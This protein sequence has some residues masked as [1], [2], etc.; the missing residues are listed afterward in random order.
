MKICKECKIEKPLSDYYALKTNKDG[1]AGKCKICTARRVRQN[2]KENIEYY[3]DYD[4]NRGDDPKRVEARKIYAGKVKNDPVLKDRFLKSRKE[5]QERNLIKRAAHVIWGNYLRKNHVTALPCETCFNTHDL[6][7]HHEDYTK[8]LDIT[9]L[10][11]KCHGLR[12]REINEL[13]RNGED[14]SSK[15]F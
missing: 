5:W 10:C 3:R 8:P 1:R 2:R 14:W 11:R 9:W 15:G 6:N 7:A 13:I 12:H 4:R